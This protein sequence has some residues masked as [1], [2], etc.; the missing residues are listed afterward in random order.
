MI[1]TGDGS[2]P[3]VKAASRIETADGSSSIAPGMEEL[4]LRVQQLSLREQMERNHFLLMR[5]NAASA[6]LIQSL[7]GGDVFDAIAEIIANLIGSE[8]IALFDY[9]PVK[10]NF[11]LA[12]S[13]GV[14]ADAL[15]PFLCGAGMFGRAVEQG[16]S[17]FK[18][19]QPE[20]LLLP[21]EK[22]L[23]A[24]VILKSSREIVGVIAIFGLL[25][26]KNCLDWA[27]FELLKFLETYAAVGIQFQRL[28]GHQVAP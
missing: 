8:E 6:R 17:Q 11:S 20:A 27:D 28:Q 16:A 9:S 21:F 4:R 24:C 13:W 2:R 12:W 18:E 7:E 10:Q 15:Q 25:P 22:K 23:T 14:E 5:L 19:R 26:Q 3:P 1:G